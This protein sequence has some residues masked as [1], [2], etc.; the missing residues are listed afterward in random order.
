[1]SVD[2]EYVVVAP[3]DGGRFSYRV[4]A[5]SPDAAA[6]KVVLLHTSMCWPLTG[7]VETLTPVE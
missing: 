2:G 7:E 1:M 5:E 3:T 6:F 4:V